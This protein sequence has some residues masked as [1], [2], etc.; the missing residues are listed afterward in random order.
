[1]KFVSQKNITCIAWGMHLVYFQVI[2]VKFA[3][4]LGDGWAHYRQCV[5]ANLL[6]VSVNKVL[7]EHSHALWL[8]IV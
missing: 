3:T 4:S 7:L 6:T 5:T 1:M 2:V 8:S